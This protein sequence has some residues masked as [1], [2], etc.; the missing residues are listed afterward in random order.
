MLR[1]D[2]I[3]I[4]PERGPYRHAGVLVCN[5]QYTVAATLPYWSMRPLEAMSGFVLPPLQGL[6]AAKPQR[7]L[8]IG[9][10]NARAGGRSDGNSFTRQRS[11]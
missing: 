3:G 11:L 8:E 5:G 9:C 1:I 4:C 6:F 2:A 7:V 10:G